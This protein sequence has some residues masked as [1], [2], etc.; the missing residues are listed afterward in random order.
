MTRASPCRIG[1]TWCRISFDEI[2]RLRG[3]LERLEN[4]P[5]VNGHLVAAN[6]YA[7]VDEALQDAV[8]PV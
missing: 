7:I 2:D 3:L 5:R 8:K 6:V 1:L 4:V